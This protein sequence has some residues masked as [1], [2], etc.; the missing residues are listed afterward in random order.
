MDLISLTPG[1]TRV[2]KDQVVATIDSQA[3]RDHLDDVEAQVSQNEMDLRKLRAQQ[4]AEI[5]YVRQRARATRASLEQAKLNARAIPIKTPIDKELLQLQVEEADTTYREA[6]RQIGLYLERHAAQSQVAA[7]NRASIVR[8]RNRHLND[9]AK[10]SIKAPIDGQVVMSPIYRNGEMG[11]VRE[12]DQVTPG[13]LFMRVVDPSSMQLDATMNQAECDLLHIG[14][15]ATVRFDAYPDLVMNGKVEAVGSMAVSG[16]RTNYYVRR[17]PVRI[18]IDGTDPRL[19]P[20]LTA[21]ADVLVSAQD[22]ALLVPRE[23]IHEE[24]GKSVVY[25]KQD[26]GG[27]SPREVEISSLSNTYAAVASGLQG[28]EEIAVQPPQY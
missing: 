26:D 25:I 24:G 5:E 8:H 17:V 18:A 2:K 1:G 7:L 23:A 15:R 20:D 4:V 12:G 9:V 27:F 21:S 3:M 22:D 19:I 10:C 6:E 16:R 28:G 13:Q 14:Q 11:Q